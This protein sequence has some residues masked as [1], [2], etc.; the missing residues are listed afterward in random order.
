MIAKMYNLIL[1]IGMEFFK[2]H[3]DSIFLAVTF[4]SHL[5]FIITSNLCQP[6]SSVGTFSD[7]F[8]FQAIIG[9]VNQAHSPVV[10]Q[11]ANHSEN[12]GNG[13]SETGSCRLYLWWTPRALRMLGCSHRLEGGRMGAED[14]PWPFIAEKP[15]K[16]KWHLLHQAPLAGS[17]AAFLLNTGSDE[18]AVYLVIIVP[19]SSPLHTHP[20]RCWCH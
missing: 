1:S 3:V 16:S 18:F 12:S 11:W 9:L 20:Q 15:T 17:R 6:S 19:C 5:L 8:Y 4:S 14:V 10:I 13:Q 7:G 2:T